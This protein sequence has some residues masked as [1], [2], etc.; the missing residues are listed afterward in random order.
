MWEST[1]CLDQNANNAYNIE[2][3]LLCNS[4]RRETRNLRSEL[5]ISRIAMFIEINSDVTLYLAKPEGCYSI[6]NSEELAV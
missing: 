6:D 4:E 1:L 5:F 2:K 3:L